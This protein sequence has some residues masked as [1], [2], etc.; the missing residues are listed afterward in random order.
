MFI[1]GGGWYSADKGDSP[2]LWMPLVE[3]GFTVVAC[4]YTLSTSTE[5]SYPQAIVMNEE[6]NKVGVHTSIHIYDGGHAFAD[7]EYG[8]LNG[9][10]PAVAILLEQIPILLAAGR[11][12]DINLD[13]SVDVTDLLGVISAWGNCL[14]LP[15]DCPADIDG[16][17]VVDVF[18]LLSIIALWS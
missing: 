7:I 5:P 18:D 14:D 9:Y 4:N 11:S 16:S 13:G 12:G 17:G 15:V 6:L 3:E 10:A 8:E 1:H 2:E